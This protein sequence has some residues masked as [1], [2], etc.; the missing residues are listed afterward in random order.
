MALDD[1]FRA[2]DIR[3]DT[4][5]EL[6]PE[7]ME[8]IGRAY[9]SNLDS[10]TTFVGHDVR[11]TS[12]KLAQAFIRGVTSA[13][14]AVI[15]AG[16]AP[17]GPVLYAGWKEVL[18]SA[19]VTA[20]HL[21]KEWNG[22]KFAHG[23]GIGYTEDENMAVRDTFFDQRFQ[24]GSA[25]VHE[26]D[27]LEPYKEHLQTTVDIGDVDVLM[28]CGNGS[29]SVVAPD[30]FR[31][32]G[33]ALDTM[34][35]EPDGAFPNRESDVTEDALEALRSRM[36]SGE[37]DVGIAYDGDADRVA[38]VDGKGRVITAEQIAAI[39]LPYIVEADDGPVI[40][41]V[42]CSQMLEHVANQYNRQ[43]HR[44]R[45]G[46][47]YLFRA[48]QEHNACLG[49]EKS[50]HMGV[51]DVLPLDDGIATSLYLADV[52]SRIERPLSALVDDLPDYYRGRFTYNVPDS[53]KF[54]IV[55]I[56]RKWLT[57]EFP[58]TNTIDG[59]RVDLEDGWILIRASNTS[60]KIRLTVEAD[61]GD[62]F[63]KLN[64]QFTE[65]LQDA[66]DEREAIVAEQMEEA[67]EEMEESIH[68]DWMAD[69]E[70]DE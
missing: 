38:A 61:S 45:V 51:P 60:P 13:G 46:H 69:T 52:V 4:A 34:N 56:A 21:P 64:R 63:E 9:A 62:R 41:N 37:Y 14:V 26:V 36:K 58:N 25:E 27:V 66:I 49:V 1:I 29:A 44:V 54:A 42:E 19:F 30:L 10:D 40:A 12:P 32:C 18:P 24:Q 47:T 22:V 48:M 67:E 17:Y 15:D 7:V 8:T 3:G 68:E 5:D 11:T 35:A 70:P 2:Y 55:D 20:S 50:G 59:V 6:T 65:I 31:D 53:E 33:V 16:F 23:N 39:M 28:D 57:E 43:V